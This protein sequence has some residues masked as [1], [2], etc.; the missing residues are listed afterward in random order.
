[1]M[2]SVIRMKTV[3]RRDD[4]CG[5]VSVSQERMRNATTKAVDDWVMQFHTR[6]RTHA[7]TRCAWLVPTTGM[8][9]W[10]RS[11]KEKRQKVSAVWWCVSSSASK[12]RHER[13]EA[14]SDE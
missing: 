8:P 12:W 2:Q 3:E 9:L 13:A 11:E 14:L 5:G 10:T 6:R 1:M 7:C 4:A